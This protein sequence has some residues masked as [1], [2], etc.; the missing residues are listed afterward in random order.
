MV[1]FVHLCGKE[2]LEIIVTLG[3]CQ[4][5]IPREPHTWIFATEPSSFGRPIKPCL[6]EPSPELGP[7]SGGQA[8]PP[9]ICQTRYADLPLKGGS[10]KYPSLTRY[11]GHPYPQIVSAINQQTTRMSC[12]AKTIS[13]SPTWCSTLDAGRQNTMRQYQAMTSRGAP[14]SRWMGHWTVS[15]H[16]PPGR[17]CAGP[18]GWDVMQG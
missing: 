9:C 2:S 5:S 12:Q 16:V 14:V 10:Y 11:R 6:S 18:N 8:R 7:I 1:L 13:T 17:W 3:Y 4:G 15:R